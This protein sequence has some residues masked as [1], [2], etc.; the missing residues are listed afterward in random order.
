[1]LSY[2]FN[3]GFFFITQYG[4]FQWRFP[5]AFQ[6]FF[7]MILL[8]GI[9]ALPESPKWLLKKDKD[10]QAIEILCRPQKCERV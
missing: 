9:L 6:A 1:M 2:W 7:G 8:V 10:D 4:S 3:Y 5:I